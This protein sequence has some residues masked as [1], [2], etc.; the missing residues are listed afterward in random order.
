M[1][2]LGSVPNRFFFFLE[3]IWVPHFDN[4]RTLEQKS[5]ISPIL[6]LFK[7][8]KPNLDDQAKF[9]KFSGQKN[10]FV[11]QNWSVWLASFRTW[12]IMIFAIDFFVFPAAYAY[13]YFEI[14][15]QSIHYFC[16]IAW[17]I[18]KNETILAIVRISGGCTTHKSDCIFQTK[19][20]L[21]ADSMILNLTGRV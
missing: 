10:I 5:K 4:T 7:P 2:L 1:L 11:I 21:F 14:S 18:R 13:P 17:T 19:I 15:G 20:V 9:W 6:S 12:R 3:T 8:F 16:K